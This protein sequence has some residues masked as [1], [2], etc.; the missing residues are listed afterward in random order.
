MSV[1]LSP[2][3][4]AGAQFFDNNGN[5]LSGGKLYTYAAGTTTPVSTYTSAAGS[6]LHTNPI[7]LDSAG[8]VPGSSEIWLTDG[9]IYKFLLKTSVDV[10]L[11]TWDNITGVNSN[12]VN[13][14]AESEYQT[15]TAGQTVFTLTTMTYSP[16]TG[17]LTVY[18]D[19]VNQYLGTS[20]VETDGVTVTFT[21]GLHVGALVKFTTAVET[22]GNATDASV[23]SYTPAGT[24][25]VTTTVQAKLR[26]TVSV[27]DFG[28]VGDGVT[29]DRPAI[30]LAAAAAVGKA[31]YFPAGTYLLYKTIAQSGELLI[32]ALENIEIYGDGDLSVI[33]IADGT[34]LGSSVNNAAVLN[35]R[36]NCYVHDIKIDGNRANITAPVEI[37]DC[38]LITGSVGTPTKN[39]QIENVTS[40]NANND[41]INISSQGSLSE[42]NKIQISNCRVGN[43]GRS[44]I[45]IA[46]TSDS[47]TIT[48]NLGYGPCAGFIDIEGN[49]AGNTIQNVVISNNVF[50]AVSNGSLF[51]CSGASS[52]YKNI[53]FDNNVGV[54]LVNPVSIGGA[55]NSNISFTN[56]KLVGTALTGNKFMI[57]AIGGIKSSV[58]CN[59][60]I[61]ITGGAASGG[62]WLRDADDVII[63]GNLVLNAKFD[64]AVKCDTPTLTNATI[65]VVNNIIKNC[66]STNGVLLTGNINGVVSGNHFEVTTGYTY[67]ANLSSLLNCVVSGNTIDDIGTSSGTGIYFVATNGAIVSDNVINKTNTGIWIHSSSRITVS[68][69]SIKEVGNLGVYISNSATQLSILGNYVVGSGAQGVYINSGSQHTV[70]GNTVLNSTG[71]GM[72]VRVSNCTVTNNR[73]TDDQGTKTQTYGI[74]GVGGTDNHIC[75]GNYLAGNATGAFSN[76][77]PGVNYWPKPSGTKATDMANFNQTV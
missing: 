71:A 19:G 20:Y 39:V 69:N 51:N 58:I 60:T 65:R 34:E 17:N 26:E 32:G 53:S 72:E 27:K 14:T 57:E 52:T 74:L 76:F 8:R 18:V 11:A 28:A 49:L 75:M 36:S 56:N 62:M 9:V 50:D 48:N 67:G 77:P 68:G 2:V 66:S 15:A 35:L 12:F 13:F 37:S 16:G 29:D 63:E 73:V 42:Q 47:V 21:A 6:T 46:G 10:T 22:T 43:S 61:E 4:G 54:N 41:C 3:G 1:T 25:A 45:V 38:I 44:L 24:G 70:D 64:S 7:V 5:P 33:K 59:N 55:N 40:I 30:M 31:L 23:V